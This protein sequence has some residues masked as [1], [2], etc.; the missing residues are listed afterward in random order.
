MSGILDVLEFETRKSPAE[1]QQD[2][3]MKLGRVVLSLM[4]RVVITNKNTDEAVALMKQQYSNDLQRVV[5][6]LLSGKLSIHQICNNQT[7]S[8]RIHEELDTAMA[9]A[10]GLHSLLRNEYENGRLLRLVLKLGFVN[11]R[12]AD[13][14]N[15]MLPNWSETGDQYV[16][17]L[18]RDHVFHQVRICLQ[19][20]P[21]KLRFRATKSCVLTRQHCVFVAYF[22]GGRRRAADSRRG[23]CAHRPE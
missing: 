5:V 17:K 13:A 1:L 11:E 7:V 19:R 12:P 16:L 2:D 4:T 18:F 8:D 3:L 23:T 10:D 22:S 15:P 9:A 20:R 21:R 6:A 14:S